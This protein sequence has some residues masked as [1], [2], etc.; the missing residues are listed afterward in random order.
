MTLKN[1]LCGKNKTFLIVGFSVMFGFE[2]T[3]LFYSFSQRST[4]SFEP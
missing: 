1:S 2:E 4:Q 3:D